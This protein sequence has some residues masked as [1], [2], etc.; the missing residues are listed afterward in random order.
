MVSVRILDFLCLM[1]EANLVSW[2]AVV[3]GKG[4]GYYGLQGVRR[5][6]VGPLI[7]GVFGKGRI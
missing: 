6:R 3:G 7:D 1:G 5:H 2:L 4:G